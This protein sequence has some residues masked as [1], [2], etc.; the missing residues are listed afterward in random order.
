MQLMKIKIQYL[1]ILEY[2][3]ILT[4]YIVGITCSLKPQ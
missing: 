1:K 2:M 4:V 3:T